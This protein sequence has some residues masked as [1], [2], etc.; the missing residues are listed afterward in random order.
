MQFDL[1]EERV[2]QDALLDAKQA[3]KDANAGYE[4]SDNSDDS[5]DLSDEED[6]QA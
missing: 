5:F 3:E 4:D 1:D 2:R 6:R